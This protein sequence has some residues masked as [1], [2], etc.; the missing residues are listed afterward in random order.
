MTQRSWKGRGWMAGVMA[1]SVC[2]AVLT[3]D[4]Q[5]SGKEPQKKFVNPD[6]LYKPTTYTHVVSVEGGRTVFIAGQVAF[7]AK[8]E[9]V[10]KGDLRAQATQVYEN[11]RTAL[12]AAGATPADIVKANTYVV[13]LN[14][15]AL[16]VIR[17]VR[18]K[19]FPT[20]NPPASTLAGVTSLANPDLLIEVE[21]IAVVK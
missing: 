9:V 19:Y 4:A 15:E 10:G 2:L 14:P 7:N 6:G 17:E 1:L 13:N 3:G 18:S 5:S 21:V 20:Q 11:L 8:G 12:A 16:N